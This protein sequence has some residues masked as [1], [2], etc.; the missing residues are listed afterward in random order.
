MLLEESWRIG[1]IISLITVRSP[2]VLPYIASVPMNANLVNANGNFDSAY[3]YLLPY[4][5]IYPDPIPVKQS[6]HFLQAHALLNLHIIHSSQSAPSE[7]S[8][9]ASRRP[10]STS[11]SPIH[12][13]LGPA[14]FRIYSPISNPQGPSTSHAA[15]S[16][17]DRATSMVAG[18]YSADFTAMQL[19]KTMSRLTQTDV[20]FLPYFLLCREMGVRAVDGM[21]KG[22]VLDLR[23]TETVTKEGSEDIGQ[24]AGPPSPTAG[25]AESGG[26]GSSVG[27]HPSAET[28]GTPAPQATPIE[29]EDMVPVSPTDMMSPHGLVGDELVAEEEVVGPKLVPTTPIM[30]FAMRE[31]VA[32]YEDEQSTSEY[33]SL[34]DVDEY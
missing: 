29:E 6:S 8:S 26:T 33:A 20:T 32:E 30:R 25:V 16:G 24:R 17:D 18:Y 11:N 13:G 21:V 2:F 10:N 28:N 27:I 7:P 15:L 34:S 3:Y 19:L 23:W 5:G 14:G 4:S 1:M 12:P 22:R 31:V 9:E